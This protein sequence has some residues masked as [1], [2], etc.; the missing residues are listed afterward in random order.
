ME[1]KYCYTNKEIRLGEKE[2]TFPDVYKKRQ[3]FKAI[4]RYNGIMDVTAAIWRH[5]GTWRL[6]MVQFKGVWYEVKY[7]FLEI[8][9]I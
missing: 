9:Y 8:R 5:E 6:D 3:A 2:L 1:L 7:P 4:W